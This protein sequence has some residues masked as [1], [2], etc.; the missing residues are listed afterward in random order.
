VALYKTETARTVIGCAIDVH[1]ALG[2]G[3]HAFEYR[4]CLALEFELR[5]LRFGQEVALPL[6]YKGKMLSCGYRVDFLV[7]RELI[8]QIKA[9]DQLRPVHQAQVLSYLRLLSLRQGLLINFH[10]PRLVD[11][12]ERLLL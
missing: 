4:R 1:R 10:V 5:G 8:V 9:I 12:V 2:P 6:T 7:N 3:L 11:G